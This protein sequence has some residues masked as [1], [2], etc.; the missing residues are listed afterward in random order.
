M[1]ELMILLF[2]LLVST[3]LG[4]MIGWFFSKVKQK[5]RH[6]LELESLNNIVNERNKM[7]EKLEKKFQNQKAMISKLTN[8]Y[9]KSEN[10]VAEKVGQLT[11][12]KYNLEKVKKSMDNSNELKEYNLKLMN[13]IKRLQAQDKTREEEL[14]EFEKVL[15]KA[16]ETIEENNIR[17]ENL[18]DRVEA[19]LLENE[20]QQKT[21]ELYKATI[22]DFEEELKLYTATKEESEFIIS[23]DQFVQ[24][25]EQLLSYQKEIETLKKMNSELK[26]SNNI[27][28]IPYVE[29]EKSALDDGSVVKI[30]KD[31]Y[32]KI[33]KN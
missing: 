24:I 23:K 20:E 17:I 7:L 9:E 26:A 6:V 13:E 21:V 18:S 32:K 8:D 33:T 29:Q 25:E 28:L 1:S 27:E 10:V 5:K 30:F 31:T 22:V 2:V 11:Q 16:E 12:V 19:L 14:I 15:L 3:L 4:F